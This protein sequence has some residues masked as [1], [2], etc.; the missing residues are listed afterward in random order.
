M[1]S[2]TKR[3]ALSF[4]VNPQSNNSTYYPSALFHLP[5]LYA[6][7]IIMSSEILLHLNALADGGQSLHQRVLPL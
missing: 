5:T 1:S 2:S 3:P 7:L 4:S 6:E